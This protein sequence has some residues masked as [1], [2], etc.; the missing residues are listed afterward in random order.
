MG[1]SDA[2]PVGGSFDAIAEALTMDTKRSC[3]GV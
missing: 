3:I 2:R 1:V